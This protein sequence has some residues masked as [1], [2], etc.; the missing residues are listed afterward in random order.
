[1]ASE[2]RCRDEATSFANALLSA[3]CPVEF[4]VHSSHEHRIMF[5][6]VVRAV[7]SAHSRQGQGRTGGVMHPPSFD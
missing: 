2:W 6:D 7:V 5:L 4:P 1:M 3:L